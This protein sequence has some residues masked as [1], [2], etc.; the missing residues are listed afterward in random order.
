MKLLLS[1]GL[2]RRNAR[3]LRSGQKHERG[4][5]LELDTGK[6]TFQEVLE[7]RS[8]P[9]HRPVELPEVRF[10][11]THLSGRELLAPT[12]TELVY[13]DVGAWTPSRIVSAPCFNDVHH[14][15]P[16]EREV[17]VANTGLDEVVV[18]DAA[19]GDVNRR[20]YLGH[21]PFAERFE[22]GVDYR[23]VN[24]TGRHEVHPNHIGVLNDVVYVT[25]GF[26]GSVIPLADPAARFRISERVIHDGIPH[27]GA[28]WFTSV[29]GWLIEVDPRGAQV[30]RRLDLNAMDGSGSALGW[31]R[32][33]CIDGDLAFVGF[34]S[35][36]PTTNQRLV[37]WVNEK[38]NRGE[39]PRRS[40]VAT[41]DLRQGR[42]LEEFPLPVGR[43]SDVFGI[44]RL[45]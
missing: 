31:C 22:D 34:S 30:R 25:G 45:S 32:G 10:T 12:S 1:G 35:I 7:Y 41:F 36:R 17:L 18:I 33:L 19:S 21:T 27:R 2:Q 39:Q 5:L 40:R 38:I 42:L 24:H 4:S 9:E 11:A 28:L 3:E 26:E 44:Q 15:R 29:D 14:A 43:M 20:I 8:R 13:M 37:S 6:G 16:V 23:R